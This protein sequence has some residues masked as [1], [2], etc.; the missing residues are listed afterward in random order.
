M[1][2]AA[3]PLLHYAASETDAD[4]YYATRFLAPDAFAW[5]RAGGRDH[6][7][8][9]DLEIGR[10]REE[11]EV[12]T[13]LSLTEFRERAR[14]AGAQRP[15]MADILA[16]ALRSRRIRRAAVPDQFP[17]GMAEALRR[18]GIR[19]EPQPAP[20][21]PE[22]VIKSPVEIRALRECQQA[23][24]RAVALA[25]D[26]LR[27]AKVRG[28]R[29][30]ER[31]R[32]LTAEDVKRTIDVAL[33]EDSCIAK[34]TIVACGDQAVDPHNQGSGPLRPHLPI[35]FDVF[36]RS[37]RT[38]YFS[39]M[40]RTVV[41]GRA[42]EAIRGQYGAVLEAQEMG[43]RMVRAGVNGRTVHEAIQKRFVEQGYR[44]G[45]RNG[46]MQGFFHGTGHGV[47]LDIHEAPRVGGVDDLL[48]EG[49]VVT[50][51]PGLYYTGVGGVRIE[52]MV[53]VQA[54]GCRNLTTFPKELVL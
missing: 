29:I 42:S 24:E 30:V 22:R 7:L 49:S 6:L 17:L 16:A 11:A 8:A 41:K 53:L 9:S 46:K 5:F 51:E 14:R 54:K 44:T 12:D 35:V 36:P 40:S 25:F 23:T 39:D 47:G 50:V 3:V 38:G 2:R 19:V 27:R 48:P 37:A 10:A 15:G 18:R 31:G 21:L 52:D 28:S 26:R 4:M 34:N 1:S 43:I 45:P 20:F 32:A 13:V 33:M